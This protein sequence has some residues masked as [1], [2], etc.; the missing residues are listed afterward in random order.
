MTKSVPGSPVFAPA[1]G[2]RAGKTGLFSREK[3]AAGVFDP[4]RER[5]AADYSSPFSSSTLVPQL[6]QN[7]A[8]SSR[9]VPQL[10]Q[11]GTSSSSGA[12]TLAPH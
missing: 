11:M 12:S 8:S 9:V 1:G 5:C 7:L 10:G 4:R 2:C 6:V 3:K